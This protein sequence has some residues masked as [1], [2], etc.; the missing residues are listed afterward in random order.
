MKN[1]TFLNE[2]SQCAYRGHLTWNN[3]TLAGDASPREE[4]KRGKSASVDKRGIREL[5]KS[6]FEENKYHFSPEK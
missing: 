2:K 5:L 3:P 4:E 1:E 6:T